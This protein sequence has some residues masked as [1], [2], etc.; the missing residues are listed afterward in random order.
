[1]RGGGDRP[2]LAA[3][4][5]TTTVP[6]VFTGSDDPVGFGLVASLNKPGGNVTGVSLFT[7]ELEVK[8]FAL[9]R[10]LEH[11]RLILIHNLRVARN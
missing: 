3:K 9:L 5:A 4:A 8:R 6:I 2:A 11:F 7:S 1:M 10:E